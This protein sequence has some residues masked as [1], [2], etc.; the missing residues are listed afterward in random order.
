MK[1]R[2]WL[3]E[4][5]EDRAATDPEYA[6]QLPKI[7]AVREL[8]RRRSDLG[9][10]QTEVANLMG[11]PSQRVNTIEMRPWDATWERIHAYAAALGGEF[12]LHLPELARAT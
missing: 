12:D 5:E 11:L 6:K 1:E 10:S 9:L 2:T 3:E 4:I 8:R 7:R